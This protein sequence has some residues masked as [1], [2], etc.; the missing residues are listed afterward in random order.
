MIYF[1]QRLF[2]QLPF[3]ALHYKLVYP[4]YT[5]GSR[6]SRSLS[7]TRH[8]SIGFS[9]S[10]D[11]RVSIPE[12]VLRSLMSLFS[13][14]TAQDIRQNAAYNSADW[15]WLMKKWTLSASVTN[16][17]A[18]L[19]CN[20]FYSDFSIESYY[21]H[22]PS[23]LS[24]RYSLYPFYRYSLYPS[25]T[26]LINICYLISF[27]YCSYNFFPVLFSPLFTISLLYAASQYLWLIFNFLTVHTIH[28]FPLTVSNI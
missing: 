14:E 26:I 10:S 28:F 20:T 2:I 24:H 12:F 8:T 3:F 15:P 22:F 6:A 23:F 17:N 16:R 27:F 11:I 13:Y 4:C 1:V 18:V 21:I 5:P 19:L 7:S 9:R 25:Y